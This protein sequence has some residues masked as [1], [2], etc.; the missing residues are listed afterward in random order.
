MK[1][2]TAGVVQS[3]GGHT[4][5]NIVSGNS[6]RQQCFLVYDTMF[7]LCFSVSCFRK[8]FPANRQPLYSTETVSTKIKENENGYGE[9]KWTEERLDELTL[10]DERL[11]V[12]LYIMKPREYRNRREGRQGGDTVEVTRGDTGE[13][14]TFAVDDVATALGIIVAR[15]LVYNYR[16]LAAVTLLH[17]S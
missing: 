2:Y 3:K 4:R 11:Y 12:C 14:K 1:P 17:L 13:T 10:F 8:R 7:P 9:F 5:G 15:S 6:C 16:A